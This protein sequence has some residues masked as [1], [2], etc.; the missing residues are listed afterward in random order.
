VASSIAAVRVELSTGETETWESP[1]G[2]FVA[3]WTPDHSRVI[4]SDGYTMGDVV[5]RGRSGW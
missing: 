4:L 3:A 5:L 1:Y 2:A